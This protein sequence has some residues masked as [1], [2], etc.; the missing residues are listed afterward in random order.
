M[1]LT[2][3]IAENKP[4]FNHTI[5]AVFFDHEETPE[6]GAGYYVENSPIRDIIG[7]YNLDTC[8]MGDTI[9]FDDKGKPDSTLVQSV[10]DALL[11]HRYPY[12][13]MPEL[14]ASDERKFEDAGIPNIQIAAITGKDLPIVSKLVSAQKQLRAK[15]S[16]G[17]MTPHEAD[18][19][20]KKILGTDSLPKLLQVMHTKDDL[21]VHLS[22]ETLRMAL[23]VVLYAVSLYDEAQSKP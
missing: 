17:T 19:A 2:R 3:F 13:L 5:E 9:V 8:G 12:S 23:N 16:E 15:I 4:R 18:V 22:E 10:K 6:S 11:R 21:A 20:V 1:G 7:M 14:P